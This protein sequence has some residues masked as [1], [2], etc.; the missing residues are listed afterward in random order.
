MFFG[1][2]KLIS[3]RCDI[4][5]HGGAGQWPNGPIG[6]AKAISAGNCWSR[7]LSGASRRL[8]GS[9]RQRRRGSRRAGGRD[10]PMAHPSV[11][12]AARQPIGSTRVLL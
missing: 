11:H 4:A 10:R 7:S 2:R 8:A 1:N 3:F 12:W 5:A 6:L 9:L